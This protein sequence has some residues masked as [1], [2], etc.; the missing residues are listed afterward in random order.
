MD[1]RS[2]NSFATSASNGGT[3]SLRANPRCGRQPIA[4]TSQPWFPNCAGF[5]IEA[6]A[7]CKV[8]DRQLMTTSVTSGSALRARTR[9][10]AQPHA[11]EQR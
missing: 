11:R 1:H 7:S 9:T 4:G 6:N 2:D 10:W 3:R 8:A 5:R